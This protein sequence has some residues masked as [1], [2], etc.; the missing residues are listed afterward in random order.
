MLGCG[1]SLFRQL[2]LPL[3]LIQQL[4]LPYQRPQLALL[5]IQMKARRPQSR[6]RRRTRCMTT[7]EPR[8]LRS[9]AT[10]RPPILLQSLSTMTKRARRRHRHDIQFVN[11]CACRMVDG[12][13]Q[14]QGWVTCRRMTHDPSDQVA[15]FRR[16]VRSA[17]VAANLAPAPPQTY[18][19]PLRDPRRPSSGHNR[20]FG[21]PLTVEAEAVAALA[22]WSKMA[23]SSSSSTPLL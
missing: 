22:S 23:S 3:R 5:P 6:V 10:R 20:R 21:P 2:R 12:D 9:S 19:P 17:L 15:N 4:Q 14:W 13:R 7:W 18:L 8:R 11:M 16:D 1:A